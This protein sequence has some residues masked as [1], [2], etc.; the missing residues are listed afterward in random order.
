M[1]EHLTLIGHVVDPP[2]LRRSARGLSWT[3]VQV[4]SVG[5]GHEI[6]DATAFGAFAER[7]AACLTSGDRVVIVGHQSERGLIADEISLSLRHDLAYAVH[8]PPIDVKP[9][10]PLVV[11]ASVI[12]S[13]NPGVREDDF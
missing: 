7:C 13:T 9:T 10:Q 11:P 1:T 12:V 3:R 8:Q 6:V 5:V 4:E 2:R